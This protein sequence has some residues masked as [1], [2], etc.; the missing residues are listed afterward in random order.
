MGAATA[1]SAEEIAGGLEKFAAVGQTI[2]LSYEYATAALTTITAQTRQSEDVVGTALK[3]IFSRIQGLSLGETLEDDTDLNKYSAA[4]K[5]VGINIKDSNGELKDMDT[6]LNEMGTKW[7]TL[8]KDQQVALAETVAGVRQYNQLVALMDNWDFMQEN[9]RTAAEATGE[10]NN[11]QEIYLDSL[12]AH[13]QKLSAEAEKTYATLFDEDVIKSFAD[14]ATGALSVLNSYLTGLGGGL[15]SIATIG[16]QATNM[17]SKQIASGIEQGIENKRVEQRNSE[18]IKQDI[19]NQH[20]SQGEKLD[21]DF[22]VE[23]EIKIASKILEIQENLTEEEANQLIEQQKQVGL[24]TDKIKNYE[25]IDKNIQNVVKKFNLENDTL[26]DIN[27]ELTDTQD[28]L[29]MVKSAIQSIDDSPETRKEALDLLEK[30]GIVLQENQTAE[31]ALLNFQTQLKDNEK[32]LIQAK[33]DAEFL[34]EQDIDVLTAQRDAIKGS[35]DETY[36]RKLAEQE[37]QTVIKGTTTILSSIASIGGIVKTIS[38]EDLSNWEKFKSIAS[39][40]ALQ[41]VNI[42]KN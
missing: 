19:I 1:S 37:I 30:E 7:K 32:E 12:D 39:V 23:E 33:K 29:K 24:L 10:L 28:K 8:A 14:A 31:Q 16:L 42:V 11:Q 13:L 17:F 26:E 15:N 21:N 4:L 22:A 27:N 3:T 2:G 18:D 34:N 6:I 5:A 41:G 9:L 38:N 35:V 40:I 36:R 20:S 25:K